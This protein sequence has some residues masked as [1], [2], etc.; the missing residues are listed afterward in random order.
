[1]NIFR[2]L[3]IIII[4]LIAACATPQKQEQVFQVRGATLVVGVGDVVLSIERTSDLPN[5][6]GGADIFGRKKAQGA[7]EVRFLGITEGQVVLARNDIDI[8]SDETTMTR[9]GGLLLPSQTTTSMTGIVGTTPV[10]GSATT[11]GGYTFIPSRR[12]ETR[13]R[14]TGWITIT[15]PAQPGSKAVV[16][17]HVIE[18]V[19]S[20]AG[21]LR[22]RLDAGGA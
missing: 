3:L 14:E 19:E 7:T 5:A 16:A 22:Y 17:G 18:I 10:V 20:E 1:M 6:F 15:V 9:G 11:T 12:A 4:A 2:V 13:V 8:D 21:L